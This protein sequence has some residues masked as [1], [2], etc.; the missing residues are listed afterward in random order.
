MSENY[1]H[2]F[3]PLDLGY[4][5]LKNRSV[6]GSM[7]TGL[8]DRS[9]HFPALAKYFEER[10]RGGVALCVTGGFAPNLAGSLLPLGSKLSR[11]WET[12]RHAQV[13]SAV[14]AHGSKIALQILHAG[15]YGYTPICVSASAIKSPISM[16]K[17]RAISKRGIHK[18][19]RDYAN[20][21]RLARKA[22]YD[23]VEIMGSEGYF[24][25][26]FLVERTNKRNDE[27]GG[28]FE[29]R[30]RLPVEIVRA[31]REAA[32]DDF[33]IIYRLSMLDLVE[34]GST[35]EEVVTLGKAI[36]AAGATIIN[37][38]IGWHEAR[39]PTI[40]TPVPRAAF[41]WV[42]EKIREH[43]QL[44][45]ITSNRINSPDTAEA[46]LASGQ[47]DMISMARPF[48]AD[49]E[50]MNKAQAG[51][52]E[53][54]NTCI[55]CNQAC[56]DHVFK[57]KRASCLVNP[58]A[59]HETEFIT[60]AAS[61]HK[62]VAVVGAGPAGLSAACELAEMGHKVDLYD[63]A[64]A[65]GGQFNLARK[66]PGKTEFN[67]TVRYFNQRLKA[68]GVRVHLETEVD[69][70]VLNNGSYDQV[71]LATGVVP[72]TPRIDGIDHA[73]VCSY[74]DVIENR[75]PVGERV[76][77][78]G[79]GGIGFD[80]A[81]L[82]VHSHS[83]QTMNITQFN[84]EWGIDEEYR[85][86]GGLKSP[87]APHPQK[88]VTL[89]QRKTTK[90]GAGLGKTSGWA[91][92]ASL[93]ANQVDMIAGARY[94]RIDNAG[95]HI[96]INDKEKRV[97]ACDNVVICAGQESELAIYEPLQQAGIPVHL[98]GGAHI[99][100][101]LDAKRAIREGLETAIKINEI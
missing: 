34:G 31:V 95:L 85:E 100:S 38:G 27:W 15:R 86:R 58:R 17:P 42:T 39:I 44:P 12:G 48:L 75:V 10:A 101:E 41:T 71:V 82:L 98:I 81:E 37:T 20:T 23:G 1:P 60:K 76:A 51:H 63:R 54:I 96:T 50:F 13:T 97:I 6:M 69:V 21:A 73:K 49:A 62:N 52:P 36:E 77:V 18:T 32:G 91:H 78:I 11:S 65:T 70:N 66:I 89:L 55:A 8:E 9:K 83:E 45:L 3:R 16:F 43:I 14:H 79:A 94:D 74:I 35:W 57:A 2:L 33:M 5:Q 88:Q 29:N 30:M 72:R 59:C 40:I 90:V 4:T 61:S 25:N 28:E 68:A 99:A 47:A 80:V 64:K 87:I 46:V 84:N 56:L 26:Q 92:R 7:H 53:Q 22:G 19:I 93:E 24:I 67:E